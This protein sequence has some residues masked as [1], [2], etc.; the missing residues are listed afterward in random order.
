MLHRGCYT[1]RVHFAGGLFAHRSLLSDGY[2][3][4]V[5]KRWTPLFGVT[6]LDHHRGKELVLG[7][8]SG[9]SSS[10]FYILTA[11]HGRLRD[12]PGPNPSGW[13]ANSDVMIS[14]GIACRGRTVQARSI[15]ELPDLEHWK[16]IVKI[17]RWRG[18]HWQQ[19]RRIVQRR[20]GAAPGHRFS[21]YGTFECRGLP[22]AQ[23]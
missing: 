1:V 20:K 7:E 8:T 6:D 11:R 12:L 15:W 14:S 19:T 9:A 16:R 5:R 13:S 23:L 3:D 10:G 2:N 4:F 22:R 17:Y 18:S 21:N